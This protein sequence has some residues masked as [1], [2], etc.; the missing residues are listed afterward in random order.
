MLKTALRLTYASIIS[1]LILV[2]GLFSPIVLGGSNAYA[3]SFSPVHRLY[4]QSSGQ[5]LFTIDTN[6][7]TV[8]L[9][10]PVWTEETSNF[11]EYTD[12]NAVAGLTHV[13]RFVNSVNGEHFLTSDANESTTLQNNVSVYKYNLEAGGF[14]APNS[15]LA[16]TNPVYRLS[17]R[18]SG[19]HFL[20]SDMNEVTALDGH[21]NWVSEGTAFYGN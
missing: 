19:E 13:D 14:C 20:T 17:N 8:L 1:P 10:N 6:E 3:A 4:N 18:V 11:Q 16:G 7:V 21:N 2:V 12:C 15:Q 9:G 5:H